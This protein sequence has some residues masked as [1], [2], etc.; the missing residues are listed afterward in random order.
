MSFM[1]SETT[2]HRV[3][4]RD[5]FNVVSV[6]VVTL[7][8]DAVHGGCIVTPSLSTI[9]ISLSKAEIGVSMTKTGGNQ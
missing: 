9:T 7:G 1:D 8:E 6:T 2:T 5:D 4:F 3:F